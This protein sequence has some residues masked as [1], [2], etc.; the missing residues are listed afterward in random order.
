MV[1][2]SLQRNVRLRATYPHV[3]KVAWDPDICST[4][5]GPAFSD[6]ALPSDHENLYQHEDR[7]T[8]TGN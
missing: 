1:K 2:H 4:M 5:F 7:D 6:Y 8:V 3:M